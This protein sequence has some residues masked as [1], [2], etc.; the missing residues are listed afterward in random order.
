MAKTNRDRVGEALELLTR[1]LLP[2]VEREMRA[3]H[4]DKWETV[5][6]QSFGG[7]KVNWSDSHTVLTVMW[8]QSVEHGL[9]ECTRARRSES[10]EQTTRCLQPV[11]AYGELQHGRG[12]PGA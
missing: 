10:G 12:L 1:G 5:A 8:D 6:R 7:K 11:G 4:G 2:F 3:V 9:Q